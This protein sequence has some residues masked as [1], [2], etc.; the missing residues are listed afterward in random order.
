MVQVSLATRPATVPSPP[1][2]RR[3]SSD[4]TV[5]AWGAPSVTSITLHECR[6]TF[7]SLTV[8]ASVNAKALSTLMGYA[9]IAIP[10]GRYGHAMPGSEAESASP[11]DSSLST[12]KQG[13][14]AATP[15]AGS[16]LTGAQPG[17]GS[18]YDD[19]IWL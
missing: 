5:L 15:A 1:P 18:R 3:K 6:H 19:R 4:W 12:Q 8:A 14:E 13:A 7:A 17:A 16:A 9:S 10:L 11:P 2:L